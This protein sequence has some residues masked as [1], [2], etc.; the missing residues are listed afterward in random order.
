M[1]INKPNIIFMVFATCC[2]GYCVYTTR[3]IEKQNKK[4]LIEI[5]KFN[6]VFET[7]DASSLDAFSAN[8]TKTTDEDVSLK[9]IKLELEKNK[10]KMGKIK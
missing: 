1:N 9:Q 3:K 2:L 10:V 7:F 5:R 4:F 6:T 8:V